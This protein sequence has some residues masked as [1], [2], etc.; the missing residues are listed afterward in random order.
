MAG[1]SSRCMC[2][3]DRQDCFRPAALG[4]IC[5]P[6]WSFHH[7]GQASVSC[8]CCSQVEESRCRTCQQC[9]KLTHHPPG[10]AE[11]PALTPNP[12]LVS[13]I[14]HGPRQDLLP[15]QVASRIFLY[16]SPTPFLPP[17]PDWSCSSPG[18]QMLSSPGGQ[19]SLSGSTAKHQGSWWTTALAR[20]FREA[21][22]GNIEREK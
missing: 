20:F 1:S 3:V 16:L 10:M 11:A 17:K 15:C 9:P 8:D 18:G 12:E 6:R 7:R 5:G 14:S 21:R 13:G 2:S 4:I 19:K 22:W